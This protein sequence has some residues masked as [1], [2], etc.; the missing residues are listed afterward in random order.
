MPDLHESP[1]WP[2]A[3]LEIEHV[4]CQSQT[5]PKKDDNRNRQTRPRAVQNFVVKNQRQDAKRQDGVNDER[6]VCPHQLVIQRT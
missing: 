6:P 4:G 3:T 2:I 1:L 5:P